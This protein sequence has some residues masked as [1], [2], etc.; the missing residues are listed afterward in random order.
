[1]RRRKSL[2]CERFKVQNTQHVFDTGLLIHSNQRACRQKTQE[3]AAR[4]QLLS[5]R[6]TLYIHCLRKSRNLTCELRA[7]V[8]WD[9]PV[10]CRWP[11]WG[12]VK[13]QF[14]TRLSAAGQ[15]RCVLA[16]SQPVTTW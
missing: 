11:A 9:E 8:A 14:A 5:H 3:L 13:G 2:V 6:S 4:G 15:A 12:S 10:P 1:M 7:N 16:I